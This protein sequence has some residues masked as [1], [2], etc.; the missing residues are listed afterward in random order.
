MSHI[1]ITQ[2]RSTIGRNKKQAEILKGLGVRKMNHT[3]DVLDTPEN[4]GMI[5]KIQHL[6]KV[7]ML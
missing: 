6:L 5:F 7:E 1:R 4:R 3:V 2:I